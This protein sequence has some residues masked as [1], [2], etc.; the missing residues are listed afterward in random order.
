[1]MGCI[2][3]SGRANISGQM[4]NKDHQRRKTKTTSYGGSKCMPPPIRLHYL[5]SKH[6]FIHLTFF[7]SLV[8]MVPAYYL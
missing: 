5:C 6:T 7:T 3:S 4:E 2:Q 1:M 8:F